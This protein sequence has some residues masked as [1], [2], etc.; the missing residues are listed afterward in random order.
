MCAECSYYP[1]RNEL[2]IAT[3]CFE[4]KFPAF[5]R[6]D[7]AQKAIECHARISARQGEPAAID[8]AKD[9]IATLARFQKTD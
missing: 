1:Y 2:H 5:G 7:F 8:F 9:L 6:M 3:L 4:R